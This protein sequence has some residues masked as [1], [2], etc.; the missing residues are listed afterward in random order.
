[1]RVG[2]GVAG[3]PGAAELA[4]GQGERVLSP[5]WCHGLQDASLAWGG[6]G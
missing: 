2:P 3:G 6:G 4:G 1:M 5:G